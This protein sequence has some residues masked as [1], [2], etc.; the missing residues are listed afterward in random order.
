MTMPTTLC[1]QGA[2]RQGSAAKD[3][4]EGGQAAGPPAKKARKGP[5]KLTEQDLRLC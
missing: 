2:T 3:D 5:G 1:A 4:D